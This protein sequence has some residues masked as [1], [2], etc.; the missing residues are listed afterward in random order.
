[1]SIFIEQIQFEGGVCEI[2]SVN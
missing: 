2:Q 1:V